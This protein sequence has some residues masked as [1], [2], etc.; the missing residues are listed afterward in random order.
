MR[1]LR[2]RTR[3]EVLARFQ[4]CVDGAEL[5]CSVK[6]PRVGTSVRPRS[7]VHTHVHAQVYCR[8]SA[9]CARRLSA[10]KRALARVRARV[11]AQLPL[12]IKGC[13]TGRGGA[14]KRDGAIMCSKVRREKALPR[15]HKPAVCK[16]AGKG[17]PF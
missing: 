12:G 14:R 7:R 11:R 3:V 5:L 4:V 13:S 10:H 8:G 15:K 17:H 1:L 16:R 9:V 2:R 6:T